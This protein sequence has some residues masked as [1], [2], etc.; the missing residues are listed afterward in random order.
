VLGDSGTSGPVTQAQA[1]VVF[2]CQV[3]IGGSAV[4]C[5]SLNLYTINSGV[6]AIGG[7]YTD[8]GSDCVGSKIIATAAKA[9]TNGGNTGFPI[10]STVLSA[11]TKYWIVF[12]ASAG[13]FPSTAAGGLYT[14][15]SRAYDGTLPTTFAG[16]SCGSGFTFNGLN[17]KVCP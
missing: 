14:N 9:V 10:A 6:S 8:N 11:S 12:N 7:I 2:G 16:Q 13:N 4:T 17:A 3:T 5:T 15:F 1:N